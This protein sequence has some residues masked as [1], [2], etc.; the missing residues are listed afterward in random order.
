MDR[1]P[2]D[3]TRLSD[4]LGLIY[5]GATDPSR[6]TK[7]ILPAM[8]HY[9][10]APACILYSAL[11]TPQDGGYFFLHG[12][13]QEHI[14]H[15]VHKHYADDVWKIAITEGNFL[16]TGTVLI[17]DEL[18]PRTQLLASNFY[19]D[20]LSLNENMVQ[21]LSGIVFGMD[22][23]ASMPAACSFFRGAHHPD[24]DEESRARVRLL[25]PHVSRSLGVMQRLRSADLAVATSLAALDR[26]PSGV[27]LLDHSGAVAFVNRAA[28]RMLEDSDELHLR[29]GPH[30]AELGHLV[31]NNPAADDAIREA[32]RS[33]VHRDPY[34]T[35][36][37]SQSVTVPGSC[38]PVRY[39]LQFSALGEHAEFGGDGGAFATIIF[40]VEDAHK[41]AVDAGVLQRAYRLTPAE[42]KVA[43]AMLEFVSAKDVADALALSHHTVRTQIKQIY[44]KLG[45]DTRTRFVKLMLGMSGQLA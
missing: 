3:L 37:F 8:A 14:D 16:T 31:A 21:L 41:I 19:K 12:I 18:I 38:G 15:Y 13:T 24:F 36:H 34:A 11:H 2:L 45:V 25:L 6:W 20:C 30:S 22:S 32:I 39:S 29:Q 26:L 40:I 9:V 23:T 10:E 42:A 7:D 44:A 1:H 4:L 43:M 5:E 28:R 35:A 17:G 27:L 33:A